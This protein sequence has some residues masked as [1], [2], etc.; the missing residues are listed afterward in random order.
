MPPPRPSAVSHRQLTL[1][2][3]LSLTDGVLLPPLVTAALTDREGIVNVLGPLHGVLF[4][5]LLGGLAA[6]VNRGLWTWRFVLLVVVLGPLA[7]IPGLERYHRR[8]TPPVAEG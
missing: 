5:V 1:L 4:L 7:S 2:R 6:T 8:Q 3:A